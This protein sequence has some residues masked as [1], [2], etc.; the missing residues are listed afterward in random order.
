MRTLCFLLMTGL[1]LTAPVAAVIAQ[2][3]NPQSA[4]I[5]VDGLSCPFC[6]YGLEKHLKRLDGVEGVDIDMK[7]GRAIVHLKPGARVG[8]AALKEAVRKAGFTARSIHR[9]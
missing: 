4:S 8:D 1:L 3:S 2:E 6:A 9:P 7:H 5:A